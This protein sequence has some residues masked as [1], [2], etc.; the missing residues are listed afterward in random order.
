MRGHERGHGVERAG[1]SAGMEEWAGL[2]QGGAV[3]GPWGL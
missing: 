3:G 1:L 2:W